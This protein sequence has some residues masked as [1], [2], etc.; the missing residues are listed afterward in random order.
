MLFRVEAVMIKQLVYKIHPRFKDLWGLIRHKFD[1]INL[2][3]GE[4]RIL[5]QK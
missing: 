4:W 2:M 5:I 1:L 3:K